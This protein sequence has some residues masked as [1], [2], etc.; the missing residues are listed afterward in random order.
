MERTNRSIDCISAL[1]H[2]VDADLTTHIDVRADHAVFPR[3]QKLRVLNTG[4]VG[5]S[6]LGRHQRQNGRRRMRRRRRR[7]EGLEN[8][9]GMKEWEDGKM[10][11]QKEI[12]IESTAN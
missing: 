3:G 9:K 12:T 7:E 2:R 10:Q 8:V 6:M 1:L 5:C 11:K 4:G